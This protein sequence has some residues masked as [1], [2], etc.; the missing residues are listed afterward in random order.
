ML[1]FRHNSQNTR[2]GRSSG[3]CC[4]TFLT[5]PNRHVFT[6]PVD[7]QLADETIRNNELPYRGSNHAFFPPYSFQW[8]KN[9]VSINWKKQGKLGWCSHCKSTRRRY[10]IRRIYSES[11][12]PT[13]K[14][15]VY[16]VYEWEEILPG[17]RKLETERER[18]REREERRR[19]S[20]ELDTPV[21]N[22]G[23][24]TILGCRSHSENHL[25]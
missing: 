12:L 13:F 14:N 1:I 24:L 7:K 3:D 16:C 17:G 4:S 25:V 15:A 8:K 9:S 18:E 21:N 23:E 20:L 19:H 6:N 22:R 2:N 10:K 5:V 11:I